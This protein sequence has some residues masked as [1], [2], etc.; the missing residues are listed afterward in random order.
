MPLPRVDPNIVDRV[1]KYWAIEGHPLGMPKPSRRKLYAKYQKDVGNEL[2]WGSFSTIVKR[3]EEAAP[4]KPFAIAHWKPWADPQESPE[5]TAYLLC[6]NAVV[7][8]ESGRDLYD[9]EVRWARRLRPSLEGISP[10]GQYRLVIHYTLREIRAYYLEEDQ[11]TDDLDSLLAYRPWFP[12]YR[13]AYNLA[14]ALGTAPYPELDPFNILGESPPSPELKEELVR[15]F[16]YRWLMQLEWMLTPSETFLTGEDPQQARILDLL[17]RFWA[18][19][20]EV[21]AD[22]VWD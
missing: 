2:S 20:P 13:E 16:K 5:E 19:R 15:T 9:L 1:R 18:W 14:L 11:Y 12:Q 7:R 6:I 10:L 17:L 21:G 4:K 3:L 22:V 8:A